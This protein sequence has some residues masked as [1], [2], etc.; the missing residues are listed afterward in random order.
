MFSR[1]TNIMVDNQNNKINHGSTKQN[2][3]RLQEEQIAQIKQEFL[4]LS[5]RPSLLLHSCCA[6]CSSYVIEYLAP[7]FDI[8]IFYYN[9]NIYPPEEFDIRL[10]EQNTFIQTFPLA[11]SVKLATVP[12]DPQEF[13]TA[14]DIAKEP[15]LAN[16]PERGIRCSRCYLLRLERTAKYAQEHHFDFFTT[17]L[18]ISPY[19]DALKLNTLGKEIE[20]KLALET[21]GKNT[22]T[23]ISRY[24]FSDFKKKNGYKRST[25]ISKAYNM[26]R[27]DYCGC[28]YSK[29]NTEK[30]RENNATKKD[31]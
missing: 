20:N 29:I 6:P 5:R 16:E 19:K 31:R 12:Y 1:Y 23:F 21:K 15:E 22:D 7:I 8:T 13:Y 9:P 3:Q 25:E 18:S 26:Y 4:N 2:F 28:I 24:L 27:Q 17:T 14:I 11:S 10:K 30:Q